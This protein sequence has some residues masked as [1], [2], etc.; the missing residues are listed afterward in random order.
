MSGHVVH[1]AV[2]RRM[3]P[4]VRVDQDKPKKVKRLYHGDLRD[5]LFMPQVPLSAGTS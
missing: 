5:E 1:V 2:S 3:N 4:W